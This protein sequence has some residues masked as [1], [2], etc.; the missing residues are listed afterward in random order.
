MHS[1]LR[2]ADAGVFLLLISGLR[3]S[4]HL[5]LSYR[6]IMQYLPVRFRGQMLISLLA[7]G[8]QRERNSSFRC[9]DS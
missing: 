8:L 4:F 3:E 9:C 2:H 1:M 6:P 7:K 5:K